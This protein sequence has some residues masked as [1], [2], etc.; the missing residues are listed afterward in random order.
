[1]QSLAMPD[2]RGRLEDEQLAVMKHWLTQAGVEFED[3]AAAVR[4][5]W[6][7]Q[8]RRK[9]HEL[10]H[11]V[12]DA[13]GGRDPLPSSIQRAKRR[14]AQRNAV[15][16][17][18]LFGLFLDVPWSAWDGYADS[19]GQQRGMVWDYNR[20][21]KR[22]TIRFK[23][24]GEWECDDIGLTWQELLGE[25]PCLQRCGRLS[26]RHGLG[27]D[28]GA[29]PRAVWHCSR[30]AAAHILQPAQQPIPGGWA[31]LRGT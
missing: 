30:C 3:D 25:T 1:M 26:A 15:E 8:R 10:E 7:S 27:C 5:A 28:G 29:A 21:T 9:P 16:G 18:Q 2:L 24:D 4:R 6:K 20:D 17:R 11:A 23:P 19:T 13:A 12:R 22:F 31:V 14:I